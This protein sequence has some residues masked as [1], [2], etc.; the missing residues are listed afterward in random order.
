MHDQNNDWVFPPE[1]ACNALVQRLGQIVMD[2]YSP[3]DPRAESVMIPKD[4][5][6]DH[7]PLFTLAI[8]EAHTLTGTIQRSNTQGG[9]GVNTFQSPRQWST[10][11]EIRSVMRSLMRQP[12]FAIFMATTGNIGRLAIPSLQDPSNR[13]YMGKLIQAET[14][15]DIGFDH[16]A[17]KVNLATGFDLATASGEKHMAHL[18]RPL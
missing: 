14:Y 12:V 7:Y 16:L 8:D 15:G 17:A 5:L 4:K 1:K 10:F 2:N 18:G 13:I 3:D 6:E 11:G 9:D